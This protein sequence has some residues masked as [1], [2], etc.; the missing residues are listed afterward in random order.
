M[1]LLVAPRAHAEDGNPHLERAQEAL[2]SLEYEVALHSLEK[3]LLTGRNGPEALK[4]LHRLL[5]EVHGA[6]GHSAE[7]EQQFRRLLALDVEAGLSDGV[8]PK[9][10]APFSAAQRYMRTRGTLSARC[11]VEEGGPSVTVHVDADPISQVIGARVVYRTAMGAERVL[12]ARGHAPLTLQMPA[13]ER[14]ELICAVLD[15]HGNR[16]VEIGSWEEPMVLTATVKRAVT[17]RRAAPRR[18]RSRPLYARWY[19]WG[20]ASVLTAGAGVYFGLEA[21]SNQQELDDLQRSSMEHSYSDVEKVETR[22]KRNALLAN[23]GLGAAGAFALA[24]AITWGLRPESAAGETATAVAPVPM[25][26]GAGVSVQL[27]F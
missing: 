13:G 21:R 23:A 3:A 4:I 22:G 20:T 26:G 15:E 17:T 24:A 18:T 16:L 12:D 10:L 7:A 8:S 5:G 6:L 9:I 14:V 2:A 25:R 1:T 27:S 19:L 11:M